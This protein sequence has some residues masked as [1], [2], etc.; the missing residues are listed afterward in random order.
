MVK[1][2]YVNLRFFLYFL[3]FLC[4][5]FFYFI[6]TN[7]LFWNIEKSNQIIGVSKDNLYKH[8]KYLTDFEIQRTYYET[9][10][11]NIVADYIYK[12]FKDNWCDEVEFQKYIVSDKEYK[13][14][15]CRF[16]WE[17]DKIVIWAHYDVYWEYVQIDNKMIFWIF[18]WADDNA[19]WVA[20]LLELT[21]LIWVNKPNKNLEFVAYTLEEPPFFDSENMWSYVHAKSLS[22]NGEKINF[23]ISL[24]MI[25]VFWDDIIQNYQIRFQNRFYP[26]KW[27]FIALVW[28]LFDFKIRELKKSMISNSNIPVESFNA[29]KIIKW[30]DFSDHRS[31]WNLWYKAYMITDTSFLRNKN[32]HNDFDTIDTLNFDKMTE[33]VKAIYW[34]ISEAK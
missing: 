32:Y 2:N 33:V 31:Y 28:E 22:D 27:N 5:V 24:E 25:W 7:P 11:L 4:F 14:V 20:W 34:I 30:V 1:I 9:K 19:S 13:N 29:P 16:K 6:I 15:L 3:F 8:V 26:K 23:M 12:N 10:V 18:K 21:R 17:W